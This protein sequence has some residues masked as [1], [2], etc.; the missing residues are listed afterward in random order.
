MK[1]IMSY[2]ALRDS[3]AKSTLD[4]YEELSNKALKCIG[5]L[6]SHDASSTTTIKQIKSIM[7]I[8]YNALATIV[9]GLKKSGYISVSI[10]NHEHVGDSDNVGPDNLNI[11]LTRE[12]RNAILK[13]TK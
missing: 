1:R 8:N 4:F 9:K 3:K 11:R 2:S 6:T 10:I 12:G 5:V 13:L 7:G